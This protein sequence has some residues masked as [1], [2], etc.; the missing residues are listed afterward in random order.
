MKIVIYLTSLHFKKRVISKCLFA[1]DALI[2]SNNCPCTE[3][4]S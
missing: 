4:C 3:K 1:I 2:L